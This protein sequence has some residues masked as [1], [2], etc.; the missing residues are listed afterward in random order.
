[1]DRVAVAMNGK[2]WW[3]AIS[4]LA[5]I[6]SCAGIPTAPRTDAALKD[7]LTRVDIETDE[8]KALV[9]AE[10]EARFIFGPEDEMEIS[11]RDEPDLTKK[12]IVGPDG[13]ISFPLIG[14]IAAAG[15]TVEELTVDLE[16]QLTRFIRKP[17]VGIIV[18]AYN[19]KGY[20]VLGKV[21]KPGYYKLRS[22]AD[23]LRAISEAGG[24]TSPIAASDGTQTIE[25][26]DL[27]GAY[28]ARGNRIIPVNFEKLLIDGDMSQNV[29]VL[30]NDLIYIPSSLEKKVLVLGEVVNP[31][32]VRFGSEISV[33][34]AIAEAGGFIEDTAVL[35]DV[36]LIRGPLC[37]PTVYRVD[38]EEI[39][40][41]TAR[42]VVLQ[43]RDIIY[44]PTTSLASWSRIMAQIVP[45]LQPWNTAA[46][47]NLPDKVHFGY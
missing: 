18:N 35:D 24:I 42:D 30:A 41:G 16:A 7:P 4:C 43:R 11:V 44:I 37:D 2:A 45:F 29:R 19:S 38:V 3:S 22:K 34:E 5:V 40:S 39:L 20:Y 46:P 28:M 12:V 17:Q 33:M 14:T 10:E 1:M 13:R 36:R 23:V 26:A 27:A 9:K 31:G 21:E 15:R 32:S 25:I 8:D 6:C 47:Y